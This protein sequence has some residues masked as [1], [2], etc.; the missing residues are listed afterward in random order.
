MFNTASIL[1]SLL[2]AVG[3][4]SGVE[5][6]SALKERGLRIGNNVHIGGGVVF[7]SS[8]CWLITVG[9]N[10]TIAP[11]V[12]VLAHDASTKRTLG[13]TRIGLVS[14]GEG[15][16]IGARTVI[17][18]GVRIGSRVIVGAGS[19]VTKDIS[20]DKVAAGNPV[21]II[22]STEEYFKKHADIIKRSPVFGKEWT[23]DGGITNKMKADMI[24]RLLKDRIGYI[25]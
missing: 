10:V 11:H 8:H 24:E 22:M 9:D 18:P 16:F 23:M 14:I 1:N 5:S 12:H 3:R 6:V 19:V 4:M 17:L 13:Y 15:S 7:D 21:K 20:D 25:V 2:T